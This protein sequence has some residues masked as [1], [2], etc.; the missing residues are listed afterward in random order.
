VLLIGI[1]CFSY[2]SKIEN[3]YFVWN[4]N[5][6]PKEFLVEKTKTCLINFLL[7]SLPIIITLSFSFFNQ[8]DI[9]IVFILLCFAYLTTIIFAKYSSFP[10][11]MNLPQLILIVISLIFP[12]ILLIFTPFFYYQSIKKLKAILND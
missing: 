6:S 9:L 1:T 5:L 8:I 12:P 3:D 2:Y 11:K 7:L 4:Y 10:N